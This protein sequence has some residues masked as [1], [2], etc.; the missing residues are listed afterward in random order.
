MHSCG[1]IYLTVFIEKV[2]INYVTLIIIFK[3]VKEVGN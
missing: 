3:Y 2:I 1:F